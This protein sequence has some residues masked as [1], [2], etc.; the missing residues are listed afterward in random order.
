MAETSVPA[1]NGARFTR[2]VARALRESAVI[3]LAVVALVLFMAL[4]TYSRDDPG[5]FFSRDDPGHALASSSGAVHNRIGV[6]GALLADVLFGLF[7]WPAL[8][9]P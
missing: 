2:T 9:L 4:A 7:G 1:R 8:L 6:G 5:Y 3:A